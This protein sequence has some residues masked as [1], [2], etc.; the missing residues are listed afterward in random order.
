MKK[1]LSSMLT[2]ALLGTMS[3]TVS[4]QDNTITPDTGT[5]DSTINMD[6]KTIPAPTYTVTIPEKLDFGSISKKLKSVSDEQAMAKTSEKAISINYSYLFDNQKN[7]TVTLST[8]SEIVKDNHRLAFKLYENDTEI[9]TGT[10]IF[11]IQ[12]T[13]QDI[14]VTE[15]KVIYATLDQRLIQSSGDYTGT[16]T[17]TLA[18]AD[19]K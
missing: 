17:F 9:T 3:I 19:N 16:A 13:K 18:V 6:G 12:P 8:D 4:A 5:G 14:D 2:L 1:I 15:E 10:K 7:I 11:A